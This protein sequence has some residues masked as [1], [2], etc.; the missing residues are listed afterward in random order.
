MAIFPLRSDEKSRLP[1]ATGR[2]SP[3]PAEGGSSFS[4]LRR[5]GYNATHGVKS[6]FDVYDKGQSLAVGCQEWTQKGYSIT[7]KALVCNSPLASSCATISTARC[8]IRAVFKVIETMMTS[9]LRLTLGQVSD[10]SISFSHYLRPHEAPRELYS[11]PRPSD[12]FFGWL[13]ELGCFICH[14]GYKFLSDLKAHYMRD[15]AVTAPEQEQ[16]QH[17][18]HQQHDHIGSELCMGT[19]DGDFGW[20]FWIFGRDGVG[21]VATVFADRG[22]VQAHRSISPVSA[23]FIPQVPAPAPAPDEDEAPDEAALTAPE[24]FPAFPDPFPTLSRPFPDPFPAYGW[25]LNQTDRHLRIFKAIFN[26]G[27]WRSELLSPVSRAQYRPRRTREV[28]GRRYVGRRIQGSKSKVPSEVASDS[29]RGG[30]P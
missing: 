8:A 4:Y 30:C 22:V 27:N 1:P 13:T 15:A 2:I 28:I 3:G 12:C 9:A 20:E 18:Q 21:C 6:R 25:E 29:G 17:Q 24:P 23:V 16:Q 11:T 10:T 19:L 5:F 7:H 14:K 26:E